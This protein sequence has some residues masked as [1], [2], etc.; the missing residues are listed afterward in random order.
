MPSFE[1]NVFWLPFIALLSAIIG[2]ILRSA[3]LRKARQKILSLENEMLQNHAEI[4]QL[5]KDMVRL[6]HSLGD[7]KTPVVSIKDSSAEEKP[8]LKERK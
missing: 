4:L 7:S 8:A 6:Q 3:Q 5:Q 2:F 1:V